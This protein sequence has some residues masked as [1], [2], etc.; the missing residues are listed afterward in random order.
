VQ[1][2]LAASMIRNFSADQIAGAADRNDWN[3][4]LLFSSKY[5]LPGGSLL[6]SIGFWRRAHE[7][8]FDYHRDLPLEDAA[9]ALHAR[10]LWSEHRGQQWVAILQRQ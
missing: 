8:Y 10:V 9:R 3:I 2:P 6:D 5:E 7:R 1:A 4:A